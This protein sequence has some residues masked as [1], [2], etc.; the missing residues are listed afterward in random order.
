MYEENRSKWQ[1]QGYDNALV[2]EDSIEMNVEV[3][4]VR[5]EPNE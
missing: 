3:K 2:N 5:V 4:N 1:N